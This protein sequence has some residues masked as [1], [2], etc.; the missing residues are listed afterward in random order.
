MHSNIEQAVAHVVALEQEII[1]SNVL[2]AYVRV[3]GFSD[4]SADAL[5]AFERAL[6]KHPDSADKVD[7][8]SASLIAELRQSYWY[9]MLGGVEGGETKCSSC[10]GCGIMMLMQQMACDHVHVEEAMRL[11]EQAPGKPSCVVSMTL[12]SFTP[13][14]TVKAKKSK[15]R[16]AKNRRLAR[17]AI[18]FDPYGPST[19]ASSM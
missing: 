16:R 9:Q 1:L 15:T 13:L 6:D 4:W 19:S 8:I 7:S 3:A 14:S 11:A 5:I 12:R 2:N 17:K 18:A 10:P